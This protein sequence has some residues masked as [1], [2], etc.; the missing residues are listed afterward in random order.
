MFA[1]GML[2]GCLAMAWWLMDIL[3]RYQ[4]WPTAGEIRIP[5]G[6]AHA[7]LLE[8]GVF[9]FFMFGFLMTALPSWVERDKPPPTQYLPSAAFMFVGVTLFYPGLYWSEILIYLALGLQL[10]GWLIGVVALSQRLSFRPGGNLRHPL[11]AT[12]GLVAGAATLLAFEF[13]LVIHASVGASIALISGV[14][15]FLLPVFLTVAH[16]MIPFFSSRVLPA[17]RIVRPYWALWTLVGCG[18]LHGALMMGGRLELVWLVDVPAAGVAAY[19]V[20]AWRMDRSLGIR[21]LAMLHV[22]FAWVPIAFT[23]SAIQS[24][25]AYQYVGAGGPVSFGLAPM[26]A[27]TIGFFS[28]MLVGMASRVILGHSGRPL[29]ADAGTWVS[30]LGINLAALLRVAAD[31]PWAISVGGLLTASSGLWLAAFA[32]WTSK[33]LPMVVLPRVDGKPG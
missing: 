5:P 7:Y 17:Y 13:A 14:W 19:L 29:E 1:A 23:L 11:L 4:G 25:L 28:S 24:F 15:V 16:R 9:P 20:A 27:L 18:V 21:L 8:F 6:W 31:M 3:G 30:F 26:H 22:S 33:Y 2:Q 12:A 32:F 10:T